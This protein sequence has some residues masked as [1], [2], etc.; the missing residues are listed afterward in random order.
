MTSQY[1][2]ESL[3]NVKKET[4]KHA[5]EWISIVDNKIVATGS[6][7]KK[8]FDEARKKYPKKTPYVMKI[9]SDGVMLL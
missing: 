4:G 6:S 9:P 1:D 5:G 7:A 3:S 2:F 8:V